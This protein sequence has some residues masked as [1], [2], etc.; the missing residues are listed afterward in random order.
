MALGV[1]AAGIVTATGPGARDI[2]IGA[3]VAT[4]SVPFPE[5]GA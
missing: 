2:R 4:H 5:R 1:E 3:A